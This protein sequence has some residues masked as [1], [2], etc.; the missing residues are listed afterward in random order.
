M[1][2][3]GGGT[4]DLKLPGVYRATLISA[5]MRRQKLLLRSRVHQQTTAIDNVA[6]ACSAA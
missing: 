2:R 5:G 1:R 4:A 3:E 6:R